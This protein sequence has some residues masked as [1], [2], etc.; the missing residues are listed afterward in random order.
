MTNFTNKWVTI[1]PISALGNIPEIMP[2]SLGEGVSIAEIPAAFRQPNLRDV[3]RGHLHDLLIDKRYCFL[4]EYD[5]ENFEEA[6]QLG[7]FRLVFAFTGL[8]LAKSTELQL[9]GHAYIQK[10]GNDFYTRGT[11]DLRNYVGGRVSKTFTQAEFVEGA[12]LFKAICS[13]NKG[14]ATYSA[15]KAIFRG[16]A[17][18][19]YEWRL[20]AFCVALEAIF[21]AD[22]EISFRLAQRVGLLI[23]ENPEESRSIFDLVKKCYAHRSKVVHGAVMKNLGVEEAEV[24]MDE[25]EALVGRA[26]RKILL[27]PDLV[28]VIQGKAREQFLDELAFNKGKGDSYYDED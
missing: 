14:T 3:L 6:Q 4:I 28:K 7:Y 5:A 11:G 24:Q 19:E 17:E 21:G 26:L 2:F 16:L 18:W 20:I 12:E 13:L 23:G 25:L 8:W 9:I 1:A 15:I 22:R 27:S 10:H